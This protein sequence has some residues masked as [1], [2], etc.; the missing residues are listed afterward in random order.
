MS[1]ITTWPLLGM[2]Y[3]VA[4]LIGDVMNS[5]QFGLWLLLTLFVA[6]CFI[7]KPQA[8]VVAATFFW[9]CFFVMTKN[10]PV[11]VVIL[12][13]VIL[14]RMAVL[15]RFGLLAI[16]VALLVERLLEW[17]I[18]ADSGRW[19]FATGVWAM[20]LVMAITVFGF[21]AAT[22]ILSAVASRNSDV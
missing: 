22:G 1:R 16:V 14:L 2:E 7:K 21:V 15:V 9:G 18:T 5:I 20:L 17:P 4:R 8:A 19:Y 12:S 6:R 13:S 3:S 10:P 11:A